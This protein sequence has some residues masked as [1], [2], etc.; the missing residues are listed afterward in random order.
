MEKWIGA[1]VVTWHEFNLG[2]V[3]LTCGYL[4]MAFPWYPISSKAS[5][6]SKCEPFWQ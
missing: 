6:F 4:H 5:L 1:L 3:H 2:K